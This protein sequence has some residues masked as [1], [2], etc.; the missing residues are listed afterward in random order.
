L[1]NVEKGQDGEATIRWRGA[2]TANGGARKGEHKDR[3]DGRKRD[4]ITRDTKP[5][6]E[7]ASFEAA[8]EKNGARGAEMRTQLSTGERIRFKCGG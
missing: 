8:G 3:K 5:E 6:T 4:E 1:F 7:F 2:A